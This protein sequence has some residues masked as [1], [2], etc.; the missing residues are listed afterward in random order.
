M[1]N[2]HIRTLLTGSTRTR[3]CISFPPFGDTQI[4]KCVAQGKVTQKLENQ[5]KNAH[6]GLQLSIEPLWRLRSENFHKH[7]ENKPT[8]R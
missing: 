6:T 1:D 5:R 7:T 2:Q 3:F 8:Y 4:I